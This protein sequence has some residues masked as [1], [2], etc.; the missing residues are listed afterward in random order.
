MAEKARAEIGQIIANGRIPRL[1][2]EC[3][4]ILGNFCTFN[5]RPNCREYHGRI[6]WWKET[7][8]ACDMS[9]RLEYQI[10]STFGDTQLTINTLNTTINHLQRLRDAIERYKTN[11]SE[12][13]YVILGALELQQT[14]PAF[15]KNGKSWSSLTPAERTALI[16]KGW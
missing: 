12:S 4:G 15:Q 9:K 1:A 11:D 13:L 10:I 7:T 6:K 14:N 2:R 16:T 8:G 5:T 3:Q